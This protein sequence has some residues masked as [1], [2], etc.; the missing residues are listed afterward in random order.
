M[1]IARTAVLV[2]AGC[3]AGAAHAASPSFD[4]SR[5]QSEAETFV[6]QDDELA[7]LDNRLG[8]RFAAALAVTQ[9]LDAGAR[10]ATDE[11]RAYQR[12]W[13]GGRD[14]CWKEEDV[15][16]CVQQ[17]YLRREGELV[18]LY[19]LEKP[20]DTVAYTCEGNPANEVTIS[21]YETELPSARIEYGDTVTTA[22]LAPSGSGSRYEGTFGT[23][24]WLK[25]N[26]L[27]FGWRGA[28]P[29][30]CVAG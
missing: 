3:L 18:A 2:A 29:V 28:D 1:I 10:E 22:S 12:G 4:C 15:R 9:S 6:C 27:M 16:G 23:S 11:L 8:E 26:S 5:A 30:D 21:Y 24:L 20:F 14:E 19:Q 7:A 13:I 17:S 25:G